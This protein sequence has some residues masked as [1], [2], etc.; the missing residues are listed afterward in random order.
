MVD[1]DRMHHILVERESARELRELSNVELDLRHDV[2]VGQSNRLGSAQMASLIQR[3]EYISRIDAYLMERK[4]R[5]TA[6]QGERM[7][8][9][10]RSIN[11]LTVIIVISMIVGVGRWL[12]ALRPR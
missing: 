8:A 4:R 10:S 7:E 12:S 3:Q 11:R 6:R 9:L 5:E 1:D 2:L